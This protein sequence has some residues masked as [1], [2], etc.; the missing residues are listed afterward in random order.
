MLEA[1]HW[2]RLMDAKLHFIYNFMNF[3]NFINF[4][5]FIFVLIIIKR[6]Q[7]NSDA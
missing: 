3:T 1:G 4:I 7:T 6:K 2:I 5:N